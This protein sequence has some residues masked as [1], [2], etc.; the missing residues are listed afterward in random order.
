MAILK[1]AAAVTETVR[2]MEQGHIKKDQVIIVIQQT[3]VVLLPERVRLVVIQGVI[4]DLLHHQDHIL[5]VPE[6]VPQDT[7]EVLLAREAVQE[8]DR[9]LIIILIATLRLQIVILSKRLVRFKKQAL[10]T[11]YLMLLQGT[12]ANINVT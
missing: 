12:A 9:C 1:I 10:E 11:E 3:E 8:E 2:L 4:T 7:E 6:A 5:Q